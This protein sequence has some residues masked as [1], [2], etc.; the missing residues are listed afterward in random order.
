[1]RRLLKALRHETPSP[2]ETAARRGVAGDGEPV[3][4]V[5]KTMHAAHSGKLS[6]ARIWRGTLSDGM[7]LDGKRIGGLSGLL[8]NQQKK[9][10][11]AGLGD[12]VALGRMEEVTTGDVLTESGT[13]PPDMQP[14]PDVLA[15][16]YAMAIAAENRADE[17]KLTGGL[18]RLNEE[19][20]SVTYRQEDD[21]R[22]LVLLGQGEIQLRIALETL[23]N[24]YKVASVGASPR[25]P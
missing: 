24:R 7:T 23:K 21:T 18:Q 3:A 15:P 6:I 5:F 16:V 17:V 4:Q 1:M 12:V 14:W 11:Q 2:A 10:T 13:P 8:G 25:V 20:A 22:Q 19:D 9:M